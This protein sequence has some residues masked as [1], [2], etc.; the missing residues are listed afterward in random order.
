LAAVS[1]LSAREACFLEGLILLLLLLFLGGVFLP[2]IVN[3]GWFFDLLLI[4]LWQLNN[5]LPAVIR[6]AVAAKSQLCI[7]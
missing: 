4:D 1:A 6:F 7:H 3:S 2:L 5:G